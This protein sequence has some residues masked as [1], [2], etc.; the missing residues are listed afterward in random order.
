M[1]S[2][3]GQIIPTRSMTHPLRDPRAAKR[4]PKHGEPFD[5][6]ELSRRLEAHITEQKRQQS[7]RR[8]ARAAALPTCQKPEIY[9]HVPKVAAAAFARTTTQEGPRK[10]HRLSQIALQ[11]QLKTFSLDNPHTGQPLAGLQRSLAQDQ[12]IMK[13]ESL[14][15]RNQFQW[16]RHMEEAVEIDADRDVYR[17]PQRTFEIGARTAQDERTGRRAPRPLSTGDL[18]S[19][20]DDTPMVS[21]KKKVK[22]FHQNDWLQK[23]ENEDDPESIRKTKERLS[24]FM[25]KRDSVWIMK[26]RREKSRVDESDSTLNTCQNASSPDNKA[27]RGKFLSRFKRHPN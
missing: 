16:T 19:E 8:A 2:N 5:P 14:R 25:R 20:E 21:S 9:H 6:S 1:R 11:E 27:S 17:A 22:P 26:G 12:V 13:Q 4:R 10:I 24:P 7:E 23:E 15:S 3:T 18:L